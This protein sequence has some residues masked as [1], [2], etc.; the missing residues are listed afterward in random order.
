[1]TEV[2]AGKDAVVMAAWKSVKKGTPNKLSY[3]R[4][5]VGSAGGSFESLQKKFREQQHRSSEFNHNL[6]ARDSTILTTM[7]TSGLLRSH[8][9]I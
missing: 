5:V 3:F 6:R 9:N 7:S 1:M 2:E 8:T 4:E